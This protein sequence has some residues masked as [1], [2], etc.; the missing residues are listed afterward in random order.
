[1]SNP[2][3]PRLREAGRYHYLRPYVF[4]KNIYSE[5]L[6]CRVYPLWSFFG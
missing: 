2:S 5:V 1:M 3:S 6:A 4:C